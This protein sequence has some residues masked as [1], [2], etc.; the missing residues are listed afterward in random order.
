M[1][2][3]G[4]LFDGSILASHSNII[5]AMINYRLSILG[6]ISDMTERYPGNYGLKDQILAIKWLKMNCE[7][8]NCDP[9]LITLWG[10]SAGVV[11]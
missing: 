7:I 10:H 8:L 4:N 11:S 1:V 5:V 6:F 9:D 2:G 3:T